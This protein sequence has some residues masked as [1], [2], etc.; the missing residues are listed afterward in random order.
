MTR[1]VHPHRAAE[2]SETEWLETDGLGGFASGTAGG[3]RTRRYHALLLTAT[4]PPTGRVVLVNGLEAWV[5][6]ARG[7]HYAL[8]R[9]RYLPH[10]IYPDATAELAQ[11][12]T[13][14]WPTWRFQLDDDSHVSAEVFVVRGSAE[15]VLRWRLQRTRALGDDA[16]TLH[17]RPLISGRDY[18][19][20]HHENPVFDFT[21]HQADDRVSWRPYVDLP[22]V[23]VRHNGVYTHAPD[24]YRRFSYVHERERG[25][26]DSEDL[27]TP[28][29]FSFD[30]SAHDAAIILNACPGGAIGADTNAAQPALELAAHLAERE[31][32]RRA[33]FA[34]RLQQAASAYLVERGDDHT[35]IAGYPWF[36]DWGRDTF[37]AMRGLLLA[38]GRYQEA[39]SIL[40]GWT[41][42]I[43]E[44]MLP[45]RFPDDGSAPVYNSVDASLWFVV[46]VHDYLETGH[47]R[48]ATRE[49]LRFAVDAILEGYAR[50]TR[51][52]IAAD[53]DGLL[54]AGMPGVQLTW[55]DAKIGDWVVTPRIGKPVEV[56]ALWI[57]ALRIGLQ[58]N[59]RW[60]ERELRASASFIE[61]FVNPSTGALY[62][63]VD[64]DHEPGRVDA[65]IRPN[66]IFAVGGLP[67][68][69]IEGARARAVVAQVEAELLTPLGL[70]SL[71]PAA[72]DYIG[73]YGGAML[74]R[75]G[76]YHQGTAWLWLTGPF[77]EAWLRVQRAAGI[78][79]P[80]SFDTARNRFLAPLYAHVDCAGL[81]HVS[82]IADGDA[83]HVPRGAPF[84]AWSLGELLRIERMLAA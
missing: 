27:A 14:P 23:V 4:R 8:T 58:W 28:G 83:P 48:E 43:S 46:A 24:W 65:S 38:V 51:F 2:T 82:E 39:E 60:R 35:I 45:N 81:D 75:D 78:P 34:G 10:H 36:T 25:L 61:R 79:D 56:Q 1:I 20:L 49:R 71:A 5:D 18:H 9:H 12:D 67:Y 29:V 13:L 80:L 63:V 15:V 68:A 32:R 17:V 21:A 55:M 73:R 62:D 77:V 42:A 40:L 69:V 47:A 74:E 7:G 64:V 50:G 11:F 3:E 54:R 72:P 31:H 53:D 30:L 41:E 52:N 59:E 84:Q 19:A 66:Q 44:G 26:D 22:A 70:R 6:S 33:A 76:A 16:L 57:N 37:I